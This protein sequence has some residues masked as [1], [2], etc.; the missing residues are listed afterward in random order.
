M[1][2]QPIAKRWRDSVEV[3]CRNWV[4]DIH[5][6]PVLFNCS[7]MGLGEDT[8][9]IPRF[10]NDLFSVLH[11]K[12]NKCV[13]R[14]TCFTTTCSTMQGKIKCFQKK[15]LLLSKKLPTPPFASSP[16]K[17]NSAMIVKH[18]ISASFTQWLKYGPFC[19]TLQIRCTKR[20]WQWFSTYFIPCTPL[21]VI[22]SWTP[23]PLRNLVCK[24]H[25]YISTLRKEAKLFAID[26]LNYI[27]F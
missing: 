14:W 15:N 16:G 10:C 27:T 11:A 21:T 20:L 8:G 25:F 24:E 4:T 23:P 2:S 17:K 12:T 3:P 26:K 19:S 9:I 13:S 22:H 5:S 7:I 6:Y 18:V 1:M